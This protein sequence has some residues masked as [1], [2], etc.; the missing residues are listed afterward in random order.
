MPVSQLMEA[1]PTSDGALCRGQRAA[2]ADSRRDA[3]VRLAIVLALGPLRRRD[4]WA[5]WI[6]LTCVLFAQGGYFASIAVLP[7]GRP[8]GG[9]HALYARATAI[10]LVGLLLGQRNQ[11]GGT[12]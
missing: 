8:R 9:F 3:L 6:E 12:Q 1:P 10:F 2:V 4:P 11:L 7:K 5:L